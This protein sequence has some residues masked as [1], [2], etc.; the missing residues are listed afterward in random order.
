MQEFAS[1]WHDAARTSLG[2]F[3]MAFW[4]FGLGY[5][6][7]SLIQVFVTEA[8]MKRSMGEAG[9]RS[10]ALATLFGFVSSSCSFAALAT[11]RSL[12]AKGA[13]L[14]PSLAFLLASTNLVV[15]LGIIIAVFLSWQFVVGEYLGG[16]LLIL[17]MWLIVR[18]TGPAKLTEAARERARRQEGDGQGEVPDWRKMIVRREG[19]RM[20]SMRYFMEWGMVWKDVTIGFTVAGLVAAFVPRSFFQWLFI[21]SGSDDL[22]FLHLLQHALVG[23]VAAFFTFIGSMGNIPLA[24]VL[25][26]NGVSFAGVMA[27]IFSDLVVLPVLRIQAKYYGWRFAL[28]VL[29]VFLVA[30]VAATIAM[31]YGFQLAGILPEASSAKS[32]TERDFFQVDYTLFLNLVFLAA[33]LV[34]VGWKIRTSGFAIDWG[35]GA[36][37]RTLFVLAM[38][39]YCW[40]AGGVVVAPLLT[41]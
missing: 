39:A 14:V 35:V 33:T 6:V 19:W 23:P 40:L 28:Y 41:G 38:L 7:S 26:S 25:F 5:L 24:A 2:L 8:R 22:G 17:I 15:E 37:D 13:G 32:V 11:S 1:L 3:W 10:V 4:A 27:F 31:H 30:L 16:L 29:A 20:V 12:F 9:P 18:L 36:T 21:G 34:F